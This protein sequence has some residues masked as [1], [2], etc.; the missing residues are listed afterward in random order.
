MKIRKRVGYDLNQFVCCHVDA[1]VRISSCN[2]F[3]FGQGSSGI[4]VRSKDFVA[5][6]IDTLKNMSVQTPIFNVKF[7]GL[8]S[9]VFWSPFDC[10][11]P[12]NDGILEYHW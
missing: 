7:F 8:L 3:F 4:P 10:F 11:P 2:L 6:L 9:D 1:D 12:M 5:V